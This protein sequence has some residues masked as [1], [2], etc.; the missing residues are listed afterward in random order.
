[1]TSL[2]ETPEDPLTKFKDGARINGSG[3]PMPL[4]STAIDLRVL[5]G[6]AIVRTERTF[7]NAEDRS[8]EA[9]ITFPVPLQSTMVALT[10][11]I[12]GRNLTGKARRKQRAR[13]AYEEAIDHGK[14]AVL[15]EEALRGIHI[16]SVGHIPPGKDIKVTSVWAMPLSRQ[17][18]RSIVRIPV[19]VG[20]I[21]GRSPLSDSDDLM[22]A[23]GVHE[24]SLM[25]S[26]DTGVAQIYGVTLLDG[27][28]RVTLDRPIDVLLLNWTP[29]TLY[30]GSADGRPVTLQILPSH[31][32]NADLDADWVLDQSGSMNDPAVDGRFL[33]GATA[34][35]RKHDVMV[36]GMR[37]AL[38]ERH[39]GRPDP[40]VAVRRGVQAHEL[41]GRP[42]GAAGWHLKSAR[43][44][45]RS[46]RPQKRSIS[47]SSLTAKATTSTCK[48]WRGPASGSPSS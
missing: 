37:R 48:R 8:I 11:S 38:H 23:P 24:A 12:D 35:L 15:H 32:A 44:W 33:A 45:P 19:T 31:D 27:A 30:G 13:A 2:L 26:S 21:Y 42:V 36:S 17:G 47:P 16:L 25:V 14:T 20:D 46:P 43:R 4:S 10:A 3:V 5:G 28:A 40:V 18:D 1:M 34:A 6:L 22:H 9:T 39:P 29:R 7:H 41:A